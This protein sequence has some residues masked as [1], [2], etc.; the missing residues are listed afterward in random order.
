MQNQRADTVLSVDHVRTQ[1]IQHLRSLLD[2]SLA[3]SEWADGFLDALAMLATL[4]LST[5]E[6]GLATNRLHNARRYATAQERGAARFE[7]Q[8]L[9]GSLKSDDD[10]LPIRRRLHRSKPVSGIVV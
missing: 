7:L 10:S 3:D 1:V 8:L 6:F 9:L 2:G 5:Q 4:P